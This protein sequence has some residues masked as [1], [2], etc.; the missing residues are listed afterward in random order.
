MTARVGLA[1]F[2][3]SFSS[4]SWRRAVTTTWAPSA[5][6]SF[7]VARPMPELAPVTSAILLISAGIFHSIC[8]M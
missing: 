3:G 7:A 1:P 5:A 2:N 8:M 4:S 6:N